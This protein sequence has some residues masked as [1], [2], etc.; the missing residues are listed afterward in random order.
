MIFLKTENNIKRCIILVGFGILFGL[1]YYTMVGNVQPVKV[2][3]DLEQR[4]AKQ[5]LGS[6]W[7]VSESKIWKDGISIRDSRCTSVLKLELPL[8]DTYRLK[9]KCFFLKKGQK[10]GVYIN[11]NFIKNIISSTDN[12]SE[13][14]YLRLPGKFIKKGINQLKFVNQD[15]EHPV[16]YELVEF[17]NYY[18][19]AGK[20]IFLLSD[21][22]VFAKRN[23]AIS[24]FVAIFFLPI[25]L[26]LLFW[27]IESRLLLQF[28]N[29]SLQKIFFYQWLL[30]LPAFFVLGIGFLVSIFSPYRIIISSREF[31]FFVLFLAVI[32][33]LS[34]LLVFTLIRTLK[35]ISGK[36]IMCAKK[37][38]IT[39]E[40]SI[41]KSKAGSMV[42]NT[43]ICCRKFLGMCISIVGR[44][45]KRIVVFIICILKHISNRVFWANICRRVLSFLQRCCLSFRAIFRQI[46]I[47]RLSLK[48]KIIL[49]FILSVACF[50]RFYALRSRGLIWPDEYMYFDAITKAFDA[51]N[52]LR[53]AG[54][55]WFSKIFALL[56][57]VNSPFG[58][59]GHL[60]LCVLGTLF[61]GVK[62]YIP[63][64]VSAF[65]NLLIVY[66][67]F[68]LAKKLYNIPAAFAASAIFSVS[69]YNLIYARSAMAQSNAS[70]FVM[71]GMYLYIIS[72]KR[73]PLSFL[74][75]F[76]AGLSIGY[77]FTCH[78][79]VGILVVTFVLY[80]SVV[81]FL[82]APKDIKY[83][84][85]K[86]GI[87]FCGMAVPL[88]FFELIYR[89]GYIILP[90]S[91]YGVGYLKAMFTQASI[92]SQGGYGGWDFYTYLLWKQEGPIVILFLTIGVIFYIN[93]FLRKKR[94]N[95]LVI[96]FWFLVPLFFWSFTKRYGAVARSLA[97]CLPAVA[98]ISGRA[99]AQV[100]T[101]LKLNL[102]KSKVFIIVVIAAMLVYGS[103]NSRPIIKMKSAFT[104][105]VEYLNKKNIDKVLILCDIGHCGLMSADKITAGK[106]GYPPA[107]SIKFY[108]AWIQKTALNIKAKE[109]ITYVIARK[110]DT[111]G[112]PELFYGADEPIIRFVNP[113][114]VY[115]RIFY[116]GATKQEIKNFFN[117]SKERI[118]QDNAFFNL[119]VFD[120][121]AQGKPDRKK[122][123]S[124]I[125]LKWPVF[126]EN[127]QKKER[128]EINWISQ[129]QS[130][131]S[132]TEWKVLKG[133]VVMAKGIKAS[134]VDYANSYLTCG[135]NFKDV[136]I[137]CDV[138]FGQRDMKD[139]FIGI[140]A[141]YQDSGNFYLFYLQNN[142]HF[143]NSARI[144][145]YCNF[146]WGAPQISKL[147]FKIKEGQW[148]TIKARL[149]GNSQKI[150]VWPEGR[151]EPSGW[152]TENNCIFFNTG[153]VGL[154]YGARNAR[155]YFKNFCIK[156]LK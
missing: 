58:K 6:G 46:W 82:S 73:Q 128:V 90:A 21:D 132:R 101:M 89:I 141:R 96:L 68:S 92:A 98:L 134:G 23:W 148:Y 66:L 15:R 18:A 115:P 83:S 19:A 5:Y 95:D 3:I 50:L 121:S 14:F 36:L 10:I 118:Q 22:S 133:D 114:M 99:V 64:Y 8:K 13:K 120:L 12:Q 75:S 127:V 69:A 154:A 35:L 88:L 156:K 124:S 139:N 65:F 109:N 72:R 146:G 119:G 30:L 142:P 138:K 137:Q 24:K 9:I 155:Q 49:L 48:E 111:R 152:L 122:V 71:L 41:L 4:S 37:P 149:Q 34:L 1:F 147:P 47:V 62:L 28:S 136:E 151:E 130:L 150:K 61:L 105:S 20:G 86:A 129:Q 56:S 113:Y 57:P 143:P 87:L 81:F 112:F 33:M 16:K 55:G 153:K 140:T 53:A 74:K 108:V 76:L 38:T 60:F 42:D 91:F 80:E 17:K 31:L 59:P 27:L 25:I 63:L 32:P 94:F 44:G 123:Y 85:K 29:I 93:S 67:I 110:Y 40:S 51:L 78:Y 54:G 135:E 2:K 145:T 7:N 43:A 39:K 106:T 126:Y 70:F 26:L 102:G 116:E 79:S 104:Q 131:D 117:K 97:P 100:P 144:V 11:G 103:W 45:G 77:A 84:L 125:E 52:D 107:S